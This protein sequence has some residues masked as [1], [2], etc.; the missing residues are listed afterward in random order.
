MNRSGCR[1]RGLNPGMRPRPR[2][3]R[4]PLLSKRLPCVIRLEFG[5]LLTIKKEH[6]LPIDAHHLKLPRNFGVMVLFGSVFVYPR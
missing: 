3:A 2:T 1:G 5:G 6:S 4:L